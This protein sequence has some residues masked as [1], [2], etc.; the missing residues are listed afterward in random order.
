M[1]FDKGALLTVP[2]CV[3]F[4]LTHNLVDAMGI[5]GYNGVFAKTCETTMSVMLKNKEALLSI[6]QT[7]TNNWDLKEVSYGLNFY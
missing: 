7:L 2:E 1:I 6:F 3:P 4:R 5:L